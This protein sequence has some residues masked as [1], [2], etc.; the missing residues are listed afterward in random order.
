MN[1]QVKKY[2]KLILSR[3]WILLVLAV[4]SAGVV[5]VNRASLF[6]SKYHA[7]MKIIITLNN[8]NTSSISVFDSIRSS[9]LAVGDISQI[10]DSDAVLNGVEKECGL[11]RLQILEAMK[12][13]AVP[14]TRIIGISVETGT[15][16]GSLKLMEA[17]ERNLGLTLKDIDSNI[18]YKIL[19][20]PNVDPI[21]ANRL[22]PYIFAAIAAFGGLLLGALICLILGE[23]NPLSA[24][25]EY[26]NRF[27][28]EENILLL[29]EVKRSRRE[30]GTL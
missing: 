2:I 14:N 1:E 12:I 17:L 19:S 10:I 30:G 4:L 23:R 11:G 5:Y 3:A 8:L 6:K 13:D 25:M 24:N 29:P 21:P 7:D 18:T 26:V 15:P 9:Q 16:E 20:K 28:K 27:F 22:Q